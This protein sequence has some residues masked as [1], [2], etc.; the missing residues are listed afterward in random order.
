MSVSISRLVILSVIVGLFAHFGPLFVPVLSSYFSVLNINAYFSGLKTPFFNFTNK[1]TDSSALNSNN[2]NYNNSTHDETSCPQHNYR[3][4]LISSSPLL[5]YIHDFV[6]EQESKAIIEQGTPLLERSPITGDGAR[7]E[8]RTSRSA[9]LDQEGSVEVKCVLN[10]AREVMGGIWGEKDRMDGVGVGQLVSYGSGEGFDLHTDWFSRPKILTE[11]LEKG[12]KRMYNRLA[13][14][15]VILEAEEIEEKSGETWFPFVEAAGGSGEGT[16]MYYWRKHEDGGVAV[17]P[18]AGNAV[19]WINL[20]ES[21]NGNG[22]VIG[23]RR[24]VHAGLPV[25]GEGAKKKGM[26]IWPRRFFGPDA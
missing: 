6:S 14:F 4:Q 2:S 9:P 3:I 17:R 22:T 11:D 1:A 15:F 25:R 5:I 12:R 13:T 7:A 21:D 10:R 19:F 24:L 23:D 20:L 26:N 18:V 16:E 8:S